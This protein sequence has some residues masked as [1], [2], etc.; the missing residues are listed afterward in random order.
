MPLHAR[1][2]QLRVDVSPSIS[3]KQS[4]QTPIMQ[5]GARNAPLN[6]VTR[7][8]KGNVRN[9]MAATGS[10]SS[11]VMVTPSTEIITGFVVTPSILS[12]RNIFA[13]RNFVSTQVVARRSKRQSS[14]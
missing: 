14:I 7:A 6:G 12:L 1:A 4:K 13:F 2:K 3:T 11:T 9:S 5:Y 10:P 8:V